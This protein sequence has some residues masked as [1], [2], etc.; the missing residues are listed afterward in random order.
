M[1]F[2]RGRSRRETGDNS[3]SDGS[4]EALAEEADELG[5]FGK[6]SMTGLAGMGHQHMD[7]D[8]VQTATG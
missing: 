7:Y 5:G 3:G 8:N 6:E 1:E 4:A 2:K